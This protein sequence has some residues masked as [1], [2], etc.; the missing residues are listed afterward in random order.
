MSEHMDLQNKEG[1]TLAL[2]YVTEKPTEISI[3]HAVSVQRV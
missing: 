3:G 2:P 1:R